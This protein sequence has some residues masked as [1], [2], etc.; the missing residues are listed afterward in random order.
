MQHEASKRSQS[1]YEGLGKPEGYE[2][3]A[4]TTGPKPP[5]NVYNA[6]TNFAA[7][8]A[9]KLFYDIYRNLSEGAHPPSAR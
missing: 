6:C 5:Y 3:P 1:F 8:Q 7:R 4:G 9:G 2:P